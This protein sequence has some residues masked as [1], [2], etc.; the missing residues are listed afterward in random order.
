MTLPPDPPPNPSRRDFGKTMLGALSVGAARVTFAANTPTARPQIKQWRAA[1]P[2]LQTRIHG[3]PLAYLD[4]AATTQRPE[5]VLTS[6]LD[7][8]RTVN[9]NPGSALHTLARRAQELYQNARTTLA[10]FVNAMSADE[11]V[12]VRGTTEAINLVATAWA[13]TELRAGDEIYL[14]R[15]CLRFEK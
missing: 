1:F 5:A 9:A 15:A 4:S 10:Q 13:R 8:Y 2:A 3:R 14:G 7:F 11:I 6:L 12:W